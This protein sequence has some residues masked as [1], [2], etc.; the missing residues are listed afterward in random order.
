[1]KESG[2]LMQPIKTLHFIKIESFIYATVRE[3]KRNTISKTLLDMFSKW[4]PVEFFDL[5]G[6]RL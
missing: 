4:I 1:M 5:L 2:E 6:E 3:E